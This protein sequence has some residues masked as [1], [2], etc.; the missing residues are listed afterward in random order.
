MKHLYP[1]S[2]DSESMISYNLKNI[3]DENIIKTIK[4][5]MLGIV[6]KNLIYTKRNLCKMIFLLFYPSFYMGFIMLM[7]NFIGLNTR[8]PEN[9]HQ[10]EYFET[11]MFEV[12]KEHYFKDKYFG[13]VC[14]DKDL[15][16]KYQEY[17]NAN[18]CLECLTKVF[19]N[20]NEFDKY[21]L[22]REYKD[23]NNPFYYLFDFGKVE[24][25]KPITVNIKT[26]LNTF[27]P[28][29]MS[30]N[31]FRL[32]PGI[33]S[34]YI[35]ST[36]PKDWTT[37]QN[38]IASFLLKEMKQNGD[39]PNAGKTLKVNQIPLITPEISNI[40]TDDN[41]IA[42]WPCIYEL[43]CMSFM[44]VFVNWMVEEKEKKLKDLLIR[45]GINKLTY[46]LSWFVTYL[47]LITIPVVLTTI[48]F[49]AL[50][51]PNVNILLIFFSQLIFMMNM[52]G[53]CYLFA[54]FVQNVNSG[55][56]LIK[57]LY[58]G[59]FTLCFLLRRPEASVTLKYL[60]CLF[61]QFPEI[62]NF[63]I[64]LLLNNFPNGC[65]WKLMNAS[66][67][68]F[69]LLLTFLIMVI[70]CG[71]YVFL[72]F[73]IND[74]KES[75]FDFITYL[76]KLFK[77]GEN[78]KSYVGPLIPDENSDE[79]QIEKESNYHEEITNELMLKQKENNEILSIRNVYRR[80]DQLIAV[81]DFSGDIFPN[82]IFCLLG[83]NGAGKTTLIKMISG[84]ENPDG[85][86]IFLA[87]KSLVNDKQYL[88]KN[89]GLCSQEDIFFEYLT[90]TEHLQLMCNLR[91]EQPDNNQITDL[92]RKIDLVE[93]KD[94]LCKTLSGGQKRKLCIAL[95]LIGKSRLVLLDEPTS[96]I[97][98][99]SK[100]FLWEFLKGYK[101]NKIIILTTHS[102]DEAEYLGDRIG[103]MSEGKFICS[104]TSS[105]LKTKY[106]C[107]FNINFIIDNNKFS[108]ETKSVFMNKLKSIDLSTTIKVTSKE[109]F[110]VNFQ[111][112]N[113]KVS[114]LFAYIDQVKTQY[115]ITNYTVST[116]SLEDVFLKINSNELSKDL[117]DSNANV[118]SDKEL[119]NINNNLDGIIDYSKNKIWSSFVG[120]VKRNLYPIWRNKSNFLMEVFAASFSILLYLFGM[121]SIFNI[122]NS[123]YQR[124]ALLYTESPIY[125]KILADDI[126]IDYFSKSYLSTTLT[127]KMNLIELK[128]VTL[129]SDMSLIEM[130]NEI[131]QKSYYKNERAVMIISEYT[132]DSMVAN[133]LFQGVSENYSPAL[134]NLILSSFLEK[135]H[136]IKTSIVDSYSAMPEGSLKSL[137]ISFTMLATVSVLMVWLSFI[138]L[139]GYMIIIP[140]KERIKNIKH[141]LYLSGASMI[142]YWISMMVVD[143]LK[144]LI[145]V[146][147]VFPFLIYVNTNFLYV[148]LLSFFFIVLLN[149]IIYI[150]SFFFEKEE[151]G[152]KMY[153][154][155]M[156]LAS[157]ILMIVYFWRK[158][159]SMTHL[160]NYEV[161]ECDIL[162][163]TTFF[164]A[165]LK[166]ILSDLFIGQGISEAVSPGIITQY[167]II[168][169]IIQIV[170]YGG[171]LALLEMEV[172]GKLVHWF[173]AK[174][175]L[176]EMDN[177]NFPN[178][179]YV[180]SSSNPIPSNVN[181]VNHNLLLENNLHSINNI[182]AYTIEEINK[183]NTKK[184]SVTLWNISKTFCV[185]CGKRVKAVNRLYLGLEPNEKFGL[186]GYNG[187]GKTT[188]FKAVTNELLFDTGSV[189]LMNVDIKD[190]TSFEIV[191][192]TI[193]Y[194]PQENALFDYMTLQ[195]IINYFKELKG[196]SSSNMEIYKQFG[197]EQ[198]LNTFC[199]NLSGGNKRKL[200][201]AIA[202]MNH[203][204]ILLLDEPSTGVDPESRR[205][206]WKNI[207]EI[208][209]FQSEYNMILS[210]HSMEEAEILCDNIGWLKEGNFVCKGNPEK[211]KLQ[212]SK[213]YHLH[214]KFNLQKE[215]NT[216]GSIILNNNHSE[217]IKEYNIPQ[218]VIN[219]DPNLIYH[220]D[221]LDEVI[222][223][224]KENCAKMTIIEIKGDNSFELLLDILST[225]Q[226]QLFSQL[227][228][229]TKTDPQISEININMETLE[230]IVTSFG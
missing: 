157:F 24:K 42:L 77:K 76:T 153:L 101:T 159:P 86:D 143:I 34:Y 161:S 179:N 1:K 182:N 60:V 55:Q 202:L 139:S 116:T 204:R 222:E 149:E 95:A 96:G 212:F 26:R 130:Q 188:T 170:V 223:K 180:P 118:T 164:F 210:T 58:F 138:S 169:F 209:K 211:L 205:I 106:S 216:D 59:I 7:F 185:C 13:I 193:G 4:E 21:I 117:F 74:Y 207:N 189:S 89:I 201:F 87:D 135:E 120:N 144:F 230:K 9:D 181:D 134:V 45:Q 154:I 15:G 199:I 25:D 40:M 72:A 103:I 200:M 160:L 141:L 35:Q 192:K 195:E 158:F 105:Y 167:S 10:K 127:N 30:T 73:F 196:L 109:V 190:S 54:T 93:K 187:S 16:E 84:L 178:S 43:L 37:I 198:Y 94:S 147:I 215:K 176:K 52:F 38:Q 177:N 99:V 126:N 168:V 203:P 136:N 129:T 56:T 172:F 175:V 47:I 64:L 104:G 31:E 219:K 102:L 20:I 108:K 81:N 53:M 65:D 83:H 78:R 122:D 113:E 165:I 132:P 33:T 111:T 48:I 220:L 148:L 162:P 85:G 2:T 71:L 184:T 226:G 121:N 27:E 5:K 6:K 57:L 50:I 197:L 63:E 67:N 133:I 36:N 229:F 92:I 217:I 114:D 150:F 19:G 140:L 123:N 112:I 91:N 183:I 80:Y 3:E 82:R 194:C 14:S 28:V 151:T 142:N 155:I 227:L 131:F 125:Y 100:R 186:L 128:D 69:T 110:V 107:G 39:K 146:I 221:K 32:S 213:G 46:G 98:I 163:T 156:P 11:Q 124:L 12:P 44:F 224:I 70:D 68:N 115:G 18:M 206:M 171:I 22:S 228:T 166:I 49:K 75:G 191:R 17:I 97:D 173:Y 174:N 90:V 29:Y 225:K 137:N 23:L 51:M 152:Q 66:Y 62:I 8:Y 208:S 218:D 41:Y 145:F 79:I 88:F 61:P 119:I 214:I